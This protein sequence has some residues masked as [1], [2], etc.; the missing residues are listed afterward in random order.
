MVRL[1]RHLAAILKLP[2]YLTPPLDNERHAIAIAMKLNSRPSVLQLALAFDSKKGWAPE[3]T[4]YKWFRQQWWGQL[5]PE[6]YQRLARNPVFH[7]KR[8]GLSRHGC[9][10]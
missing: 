5:F 6:P 9:L 7:F 8:S 2:H 4:F 10:D 1:Q 3:S